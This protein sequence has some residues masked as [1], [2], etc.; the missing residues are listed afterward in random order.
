MKKIV[1]N[2]K[3]ISVFVL[4]LMC[5]IFVLSIL[6]FGPMILYWNWEENKNINECIQKGETYEKCY[7]LYNW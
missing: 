2:L 1:Y 3:S 6:F 5:T 4:K 7:E